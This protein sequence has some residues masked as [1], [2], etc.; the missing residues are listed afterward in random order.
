MTVAFSDAIQF[1]VSKKITFATL[2]F[3][4]KFFAWAVDGGEYSTASTEKVISMLEN[5]AD[6]Q[7][8]STLGALQG[9]TVTAVGGLF[10]DDVNDKLVI[11]AKDDDPPFS[12][13]YI[14]L[15]ELYMSEGP[16][17]DASNIFEPRILRP[18]PINMKTAIRFDGKLAKSGAGGV[19]IQNVDALLSRKELEP[20]GTMEIKTALEI[21]A[22][23]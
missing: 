8:F 4:R 18:P 15:V 22:T 5:N 23:V 12:N 1:A 10:W 19:S 16:E 17:E 9:A 6:M 2:N 3:R 14:G 11:R 13:L 7:V 21:P 20:D